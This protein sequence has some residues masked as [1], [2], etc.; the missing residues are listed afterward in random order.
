MLPTTAR[1]TERLIESST[2]GRTSQKCNSICAALLAHLYKRAIGLLDE[3]GRHATGDV[4][5]IYSVRHDHHV[6]GTDLVVTAA[7]VVH[8]AAGA[9]VGFVA[10]VAAGAVAAVS[11]AA[12]G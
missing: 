11:A 2:N 7:T 12:V 9:G 1:A 10:A 3:D 4:G 8:A 5:N 6:V